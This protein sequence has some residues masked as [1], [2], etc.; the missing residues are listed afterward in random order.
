MVSDPFTSNENT[1][2]NLDMATDTSQNPNN[3][4]ASQNPNTQPA[5]PTETPLIALN[6]AAQ[7]NGK[8]TSSTFSQWCAQ[9]E[10][11]LIVYDL[12]DYVTDKTVSQPPMAPSTLPQS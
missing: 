6:I 1:I 9:F 8:L 7:I 5:S 2:P 11:L 10:A 4:L 12:L 3:H